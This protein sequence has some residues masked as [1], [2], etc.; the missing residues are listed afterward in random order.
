VA[1]E[2][3]GDDAGSRA[4]HEGRTHRSWWRRPLAADAIRHDAIQEVAHLIL[5]GHQCEERR[6]PLDPARER[7]FELERPLDPRREDEDLGL[8]RELDPLRCFD[9]R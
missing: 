6:L 9:A 3:I 7:F 5:S 8:L 4:D 1:Q 2:A